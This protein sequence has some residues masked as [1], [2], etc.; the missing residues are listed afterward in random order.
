MDKSNKGFVTF[1][2]F[3]A[4]TEFSKNPFS[5]R[6]FNMLKVSEKDQTIDFS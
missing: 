4:I 1:S 5:E 3:M 6:I 2:D